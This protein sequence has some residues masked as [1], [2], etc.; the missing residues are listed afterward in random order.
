MLREH[1]LTAEKQRLFVRYIL[2]ELAMLSCMLLGNV[3][4]LFI[5]A[6]TILAL[7]KQK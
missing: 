5:S 2:R 3:E 6:R 7:E 1:Q 4:M